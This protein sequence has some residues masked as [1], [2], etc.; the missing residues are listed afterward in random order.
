MDYCISI[1]LDDYI[2]LAPPTPFAENDATS[3]YDVM[4]TIYEAEH[5]VKIIGQHATYTNIK[6]RIEVTA[7]KI[8]ADDRFFLFYAGHGKDINGIPHISCYD[9]E[10][11]QKASWHSLLE[12]MERINSTGCNK[13]IFFID[14]CESTLKLGSRKETINKFSTDELEE[15]LNNSLYSCVFSATSHKG[16]ADINSEEQ[17]G[18]WSHYLIKGLKGEDPKALTSEDYLTNYSLQK[19][20][21]IS[22]KK[23]CK[24]NPDVT[25]QYAH[26]W[27][28][29]EGEFIIKDFSQGQVQIYQDVPKSSI[30]RIELCTQ[31]ERGI[32]NLSGFKKGIHTVPKY[33]SE[34]TEKFVRN[35]SEKEIKDQIEEI[36]GSLRGLLK[37]RRRDF[38]VTLDH[39]F[40]LFECPYFNYE[41]N[42]EIDKDDSTSALFIGRLIPNDIDKLIEVSG[43]IDSC[44]PE[45]FDTL[46]YT[47]SKTINLKQLIDKIEEQDDETMADF[48]LDY[49]AEITYIELY[50]TALERTVVIT[51]QEVK[52]TFRAKEKIPDMLGSL[53]HLSNQLLLVSPKYKLLE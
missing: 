4:E 22:V 13:V 42:V 51:P 45:W 18:I 46:I 8:E 19:Y 40:G 2:H 24:R 9:S 7:S 12:L 48:E 20:L 33:R 44:F 36:S 6:N 30:K 41:Y 11:A 25:I 38:N 43:E 10:Y 31:S 49:D 47:L 16:V 29:E 39:G 50:N 32:K 37:L 5:N 52:F 21:N 15:H 26:S 27:G 3:F 17:H 14:A 53:K 1:G 34:A 35:I 28:K 23:Y